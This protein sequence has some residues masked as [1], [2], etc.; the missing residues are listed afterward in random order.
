MRILIINLILSTAENGIITRRS[1]N[2]DTMIY[3]FAKGFVANGHS[4]TICASEEYRP[5]EAEQNEFEV[6]FFKSVLPKVFKVDLI[7]FPKGLKS[8]VKKNIDNYDVVIASEVFQ[9]STLLISN[10]C[11][12]KLVIWQELSMHN[13]MFFQLPSK[14]WYNFIVRFS[15]IKHALIVGRSESAKT[16]IGNF[17]S[18]VSDDVVE[19]GANGDL[20]KPIKHANKNFVVLSQLIKRKNIDSIIRKF[21]RLV[22]IEKYS[23]FKLNI[24]GEGSE[25]SNL[26]KLVR[27]FSLESNVKFHG[28]LRHKEAV[29]FLADSYALLVDT[30]KDL[31]MVT[32]PEAIV[33]GTPVLMNTLPN[34]ASFVSENR[35]GIAKDN[36][37]EK[38]LMDII[39]NYDEFHDNCIKIRE[40]ITNVGSAKKMIDIFQ[41][42]KDEK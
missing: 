34:T 2:Q 19:H 11:K 7:P 42:F 16:F 24:I 5:T 1:S 4:V 40:Q 20:L 22:Q 13:N 23:D 18:H 39:E 9:I 21:A 27:N 31:N 12:G 10:I 6:I 3:N 38:D 26:E 32:V 17:L 35:L 41:K 15:G 29:A 28:F 25:R 14:F 8:F 30:L 36:W 37:D 33:S